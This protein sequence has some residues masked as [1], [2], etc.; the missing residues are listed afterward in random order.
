VLF[1]STATAVIQVQPEGGDW[2]SARV[3]EAGSESVTI[4]LSGFTGD[5]VTVRF[6]WIGGATDADS[7]TIADVVASGEEST[8]SVT[9]AQASPLQPGA[10]SISG[11]VPQPNDE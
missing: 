6:V 8:D 11:E 2:Q 10:A 5:R 3:L 7:W 9:P 1:R 4:D